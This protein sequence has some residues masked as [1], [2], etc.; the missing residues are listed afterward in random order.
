[1]DCRF[2]LSLVQSAHG[3]HTYQSLAVVPDDSALLV[4][5][6]LCFKVTEGG[7]K[8]NPDLRMYL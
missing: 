4:S 3:L 1:M 2:S 8:T 7:K 5:H 6:Y